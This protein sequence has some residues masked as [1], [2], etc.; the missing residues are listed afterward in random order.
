MVIICGGEY[1]TSYQLTRQ[2]G[3]LCIMVVI[4]AGEYMTLSPVDQTDM[5]S[6]Q[7]DDYIGW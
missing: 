2:T 5:I 7:H 6:V 4:K 3:C 1:I